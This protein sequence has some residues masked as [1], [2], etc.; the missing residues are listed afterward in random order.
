MIKIKSND[1][2]FLS[3][4]QM[5]NYDMYDGSP[6]IDIVASSGLWKNDIDTRLTALEDQM[7][8]LLAKELADEE[9]RRSNAALLDAWEKYQLTL[10]LV[11]EHQ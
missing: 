10:Q 6:R 9:L 3:I 11:K 4:T 7:A 5:Q 2:E 8:A 1:E